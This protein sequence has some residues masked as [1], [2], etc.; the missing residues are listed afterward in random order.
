MKG[1]ES[2]FRIE[3]VTFVLKPVSVESQKEL[4][5]SG[6]NSSEICI[7]NVQLDNSTVKLTLRHIA[8]LISGWFQETRARYHK[9]TKMV[10]LTSAFDN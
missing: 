7:V 8:D 10:F 6:L 5:D 9:N 3:S 1:E 4:T 2:T